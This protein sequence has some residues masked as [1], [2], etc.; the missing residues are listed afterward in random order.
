MPQNSPDPSQPQPVDDDVLSLYGNHDIDQADHCVNRTN[1]DPTDPEPDAVQGQGSL[2]NK[3]A[4]QDH[5]ELISSD[6]FLESIDGSASIT[7]LTDPPV[8]ANLA[9]LVNARFKTE[10]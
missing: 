1:D 9:T 10:L 4:Q 8:S 3:T 2:Q 7:A 6:L 5:E